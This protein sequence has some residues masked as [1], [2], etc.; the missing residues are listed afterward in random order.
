MKNI[1]IISSIILF[2]ILTSFKNS[3][4]DSIAESPVT[5]F[6]NIT[7]ESNVNK[8]LFSYPIT[9]Q[10]MQPSAEPQ[11]SGSMAD[12]VVPVRDFRCNNK[13]AY[14]DF[15]T[16]LKAD[17]YPDLIISIPRRAFRQIM[18]E[19]EFTLHNI[20]INIAGVSK[21]YDI[22]CKTEPDGSGNILVGTIVVD[23][24][25]L[26]ITPPIKYF[27]MVRIKDEVIVKFGLGLLSQSFARM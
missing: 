14:R 18:S 12:I 9:G 6:L 5:G 11:K 10:N 24:T 4:I 7:V 3:G 17:Q 27:G 13:V 16:L 23:L 21:K 8:V 15:V 2:F 25:D 20:L 26:N 19:S 22:T 1:T